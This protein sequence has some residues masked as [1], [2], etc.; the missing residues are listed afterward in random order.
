MAGCAN[1]AVRTRKSSVGREIV[2]R[3][4]QAPYKVEPSAAPDP[5]AL[6]VPFRS[7][8]YLRL[9]LREVHSSDL[10]ADQGSALLLVLFTI[11]LIS[12][13]ILSAVE[14][15]KHDVDEY[16]ASS[17]EFR[18]RQLAVSGLAFGTNPQVRNEDRS[19]LEQKMPDGG[20]F[21]VAIS[22]ESTRLNINTI[23]QNGREYLLETLFRRW[24][25]A[26][27]D[28]Q[29]AVQGLRNWVSGPASNQ[30]NFQAQQNQPLTNQVQANQ[31]LTNQA[32][33]PAQSLQGVPLVNPFQAVEE[34]SLVSEFAPVMA[35][36]P[37]WADHFTVWG[38]GK[39]DVNLADAEMI[40]LVTGVPTDLAERFVKYRWGPDGIPFTPDDQVY[41][42]LDQ[43][44]AALGMSPEQFQLVQDL[45]SLNSSVD[46]IESTGIISSYTKTIDVIV[47]RNTI[48]IRYLVWQEK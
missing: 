2:G 28:V 7:V 22:S 37:D 45:L 48:P 36:R 43:V 29:P 13:L 24:G 40:S 46:R 16:A 38:D 34:M 6:Q 12:G 26:D 4:G 20:Q 31:P 19:I 5:G 47:S 33:Q 39:I 44:R 42:S 41:L 27:K 32:N 35:A 10:A 14:F 30:Q 18:A 1:H 17:R 3:L 15:V 25:V 23:L 9:P 21:R 8:A 11:L